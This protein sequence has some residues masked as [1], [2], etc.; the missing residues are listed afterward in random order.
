MSQPTLITSVVRA[1][2]LLDTV[3]AQCGPVPA[4]KL[5]R[6]TGLPLA[7]TYHLLR[8]LLHEGYLDREDGGYV[9]GAQVSTLADR[10]QEDGHR[11]HGVLRGLHDELHAPAYLSV[12][13]DGEIRL[14]DVADSPDAPRTDMWVGFE[15]AAHATALGKAVLASLPEARCRDY[16]SEHPLVDLTSATVTSRRVLLQQLQ[17]NPEIATDEQEYAVGVACMAVPVPSTA[18]VGAV[19]ISV[20][21]ERRSAL[22]ASRHA[23][24]RAAQ[25]IALARD[26]VAG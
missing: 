6:L 17:R 4:K 15:D 22:L 18:I 10:R 19:A 5:A 26:A 20:P 8:T 21:L 23:L 16:L 24:R 25:L 11:T 14:V 3:G 12:L 9:L 2:S 7:T 13:D 1:L